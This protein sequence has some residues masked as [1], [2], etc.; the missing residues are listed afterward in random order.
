MSD[1]RA[2][3]VYAA[4]GKVGETVI[5]R[6]LTGTTVQIP[7]DVTVKA[8]VRGYG[9]E[10]L[11]GGVQQGDRK[12]IMS[13]REM[14]NAQWCWPVKPQDRIIID[15]KA[16]VVQSVDGRKIGEDIAMYVIQTRG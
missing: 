12:V 5:V 3:A 4:C 6:R 1:P 8:V 7:F 15:G 9:P 2:D 10:E 16:T 13:Q 11:V 14:E